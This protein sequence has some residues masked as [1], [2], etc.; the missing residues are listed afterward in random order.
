MNSSKTRDAAAS[1]LN[2]E[3]KK[4]SCLWFGILEEKKYRCFQ[5][6]KVLIIE[7]Q[8]LQN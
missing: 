2:K 8:E 6:G 7:R 4:V 3:E 5:L 1:I